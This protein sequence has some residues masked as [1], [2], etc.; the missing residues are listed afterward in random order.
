MIWIY[1]TDSPDFTENFQKK[2][3][4][5]I[6]YVYI[7]IVKVAV[8][9][10][11]NSGSLTSEWSSFLKLMRS[12]EFWSLLW[13]CLAYDI[14]VWKLYNSEMITSRPGF[15]W[16]AA[17][18]LVFCWKVLVVGGHSEYSKTIMKHFCLSRQIWMFVLRCEL[19][20]TCV[21]CSL[22]SFSQHAV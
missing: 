7:Y 13:K 21:P 2:K 9:I 10:A 3:K 19:W 6:F 22:L 15:F 14:Q 5:S 20:G 17:V 1:K 4:K 11:R 18:N 8:A 16:Q 12:F